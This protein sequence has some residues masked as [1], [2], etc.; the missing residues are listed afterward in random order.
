MKKWVDTLKRVTKTL[1]LA[2][3]IAFI[4]AMV[5]Q[6]VVFLIGEATLM[7]T[8]KFEAGIIF[9]YLV[10]GTVFHICRMFNEEQVLEYLELMGGNSKNG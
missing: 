10:Y 6:F 8:I 9:L 2:V 1:P 4:L 3:K 7:Y 5:L